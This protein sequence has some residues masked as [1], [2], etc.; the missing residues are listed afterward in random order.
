MHKK[1]EDANSTSGSMA[2]E[3][4]IRFPKTALKQQRIGEI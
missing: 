2:V 4:Y 3:I 1:R